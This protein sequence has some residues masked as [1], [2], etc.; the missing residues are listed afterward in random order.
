M[1]VY[2]A[3]FLHTHISSLNFSILGLVPQEM[4]STELDMMICDLFLLA[5]GTNV[6][7]GDPPVVTTIAQG[8][9]IN[10]NVRCPKNGTTLELCVQNGTSVL[11]ASDDIETPGEALFDYRLIV[12]NGS[13][14]SVFVL[15]QDFCSNQ[16]PNRN[17]DDVGDSDNT[18]HITIQGSDEN[19]T[20]SI[21]TTDGDTTT[22]T[23]ELHIATVFRW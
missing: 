5:V 10:L 23:G 8:E 1:N 9:R 16:N 13:C 4:M 19:N 7:V 3:I 11:Y 14:E 12:G 17:P 15:C 22:P 20:V 21:Q 6:T 18:I 2:L